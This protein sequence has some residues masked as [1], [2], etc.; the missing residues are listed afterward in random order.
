[1]KSI[2]KTI[3]ILLLVALLIGGGSLILLSRNL[4]F[5]ITIQEREPVPIPT[6]APVEAFA[7]TPIVVP[8]ETQPELPADTQP[9]PAMRTITATRYFAYDVRD[10]VYLAK[11]GDSSEKLYPASITKLL[12]AYLVLQY[13]RPEDTIVVGDALSMVAEDSSVAGLQAGDRLTTAQLLSAMMLPSGND[14][15]QAAAVAVGR[16][17]A[18]DDSLSSGQAVT[19]FVEQMNA[20]AQ[21]MGM[22]NSHFENPDGYHHDNHYTTM[23]DLVLLCQKVLAEPMLLACTSRAEETAVLSGRTLE[24]ENTNLLVNSDAEVY[25]PNTIG[26]KTGY[27]GKAGSCLVS[28]FFMEDRLWLIGVFG[29]PAFT[30]DRYLDTVAIYESLLSSTNH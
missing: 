21:A 30:E 28:A 22:T 15:A 27:T 20:Q 1:M 12:T 11:L 3:L 6:D 13:L 14:A 7:D 10:G 9:Q 8:A 23:D 17:I 24:W 2:M 25:L 29:C 18:G 26:L 4:I 19:V 5:P 16:M